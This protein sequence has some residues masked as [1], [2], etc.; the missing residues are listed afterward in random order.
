[1]S[2][3]NLTRVLFQMLQQI[4][5]Y[6]CTL[7]LRGFQS[8]T[9]PCICVGPSLVLWLEPTHHQIQSSVTPTPTS[10]TWA[11]TPDPQL[12]HGECGP[13]GQHLPQQVVW[14]QMSLDI[15]LW[16]WMRE[17]ATGKKPVIS[18]KPRGGIM[19]VIKEESTGS[20]DSFGPATQHSVDSESP[21]H[22]A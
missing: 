2:F 5:R 19:C 7:M 14:S 12:N 9:N 4:N 11:E 10:Q 18:K 20:S 1:M 17:L 3:S 15:W 6:R 21:T 8:T 13:V 22:N 16:V